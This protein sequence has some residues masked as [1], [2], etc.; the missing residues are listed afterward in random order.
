[1]TNTVPT[2]PARAAAPAAAPAGEPRWQLRLL[3]AVEL[4]DGTQRIDRFPSR[5]VAAL[6]ARLALAPERAHA[7]EELVELLWPGV[8]LD[9]GRNRLRQALSTLKS[10]LEPA[11][12]PG[13]A[14]LQADRLA[15]RVVRGAIGCD[16]LDF[17]RALRAGRAEE[18]RAHHGG[19]LMPGYYDEWIG[20]ERQRLL[21]LYERLP[22]QAASPVA[23]AATDAAAPSAAAFAPVAIIA[24]LPTYLTRLFGVDMAAARLRALVLSR[25]LVTLLGPGGSGKTRLAVEVAQSLREPQPWAGEGGVAAPFE[26]ISFVSLVSCEDGAQLVEA[27]ARALQLPPGAGAD[28]AALV[29]W[30][31]GRRVLLVLDNF[32]QLVGRAEGVVAA[33]LSQLPALHVLVTSRRALGLDGEQHVA[34]EPLALPP[35]DAPPAAAAANPAVAL[36]VDRARAART[37]FHLGERNH[38]AIVALVRALQG[39]P[40]AIELAA[41]R[42]RSFPPAEMVAMLAAGEGR[43]H[44]ALLARG[45]PRA[46]HD[47]RHASMAQVIAWSWRLL[48]APAQRV[49]QALTLFPAD[50]ATAAVAAV[51]GDSVADTAARLDDLV[52]HTLVRVASAGD[53]ADDAAPRFGLLEPVREFVAETL[54]AEEAAAMATRLWAWLLQW[55][56]TLG[57]YAV[58]ADVA[59]E[60]PL[61]H[62]QLAQAGRA[63][64]AALALA[65]AL[66]RYWETD[67][68]PGRVLAALEDALAL[69]SGAALRADAHELLA[70]LRFGSGQVELARS[71]AEAAVAGAGNEPVRRARALVRRAWVDIAAGW[72]EDRHS[73]RFAELAA[74]LDEALSLAR[75]SGDIEAQ[76]RALQQQAIMNGHVHFDTA[77]ADLARA[78]ALFAQSQA[79]WLALGDRRQAQARLRNR[80][81]CWVAMGRRT[82]ARAIFEQCEQAARDDGDWVGQMDCQISLSTVMAVPGQWAAALQACRT[83]IALA[84]GRWHRHGLAYGLWNAPRLLAHLHRPEAAMKLLGF[85]VQFWTLGFGP[86]RP[87]DERYVRRVRGLVRAQLG[88]VRAEALW[89]EG[90]AMD[91]AAAVRL[92]QTA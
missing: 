10:L 46:G 53:A 51:L 87:D 30:L 56:Q 76:A 60:L 74:D 45:G 84:W 6:L 23:A 33:L 68:L 37:D 2:H 36:F 89:R 72:V 15:V 20:D 49:M 54:P 42:V 9:V 24:P 73:A 11:G 19:E 44:L 25:R 18:A 21:A 16:V 55:T 8:A 48:D 69:V 64:Q 3:G 61:V 58:P 78:E 66:R 75:A 59:P 14:V 4:H 82:E 47:A 77:S 92:A 27:S 85:T 90:T 1:M 81:Q 17:E 62:A 70:Y 26:R 31:A 7:R 79:L 43:A 38:A 39:L 28:V 22:D 12:T 83:A 13:T 86:L 91:L 57:A 71:H 5:A 41:S 40:L 52:A 50:A 34:A 67:S 65:L 35:S 29:P 88:A 80:A 32:E 63:P